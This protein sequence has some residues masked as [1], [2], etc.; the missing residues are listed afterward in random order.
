MTHVD[1]FSISFDNQYL[2]RFVSGHVSCSCN[3]CY[4]PETAVG[5]EGNIRWIIDLAFNVPT[6]TEGRRGVKRK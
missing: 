4:L 6:A 1:F 5:Q 2:T 3:W